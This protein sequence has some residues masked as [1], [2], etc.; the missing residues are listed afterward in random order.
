MVQCQDFVVHQL[1]YPRRVEGEEEEAGSSG[2]FSG[3]C[4]GFFSSINA[5]AGLLVDPH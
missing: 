1:A 3:Y 4:P 2:F 5:H